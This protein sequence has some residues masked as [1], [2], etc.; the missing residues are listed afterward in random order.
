MLTPET[1]LI[2]RVRERMRLIAGLDAALSGRAGLAMLS[3]EAGIGKTRLAEEVAGEA[4][5]RGIFTAWGRCDEEGGAPPYWPWIQVIRC[6]LKRF[7]DSPA[8]FDLNG[9]G[10]ETILAAMPNLVGGSSQRLRTPRENPHDQNELEAVRF[11]LFDS[12]ATRLLRLS[13]QH[14]LVIIFDDL[15]AADE[16]SLLLLRFVAK[17]AGHARMFVVATYRDFEVRLAPEGEPIFADLARMAESLPLG[18]MTGEEVGEFIQLFCGHLPARA[19]SDRLR[20]TTNGN[21]F[22]VREIVRLMFAEGD[23]AALEGGTSESFKIPDGVRVTIQRRFGFLPTSSLPILNAAAV[24]GRRFHAADLER[25]TGV[26]FDTVISTLEKMIIAGVMVKENVA[27]GAFQFSH[28]LFAESLYQSLGPTERMTLHLKIAE[29]IEQYDAKPDAAEL[30]WHYSRSLP[31]GRA[32]NAVKFSRVAAE[33]AQNALAYQDAAVFYATALTALAAIPGE[34]R[35]S[36]CELLLGLGES[37]YLAGQFE[38]FRAT[39][40]EALEISRAL[41][42]PRLFAKAVLGFNSLPFEAGTGGESV[43]RLHE[44]ALQMLGESE[45]SLRVK[46]LGELA[47]CLGRLGWSGDRQSSELTMQAVELA[48]RFKAPETLAEALFGRYFSLR[49]PDDMAQRLALSEELTKIVD[50][51][52][53]VGWSFRT[54]YYRGA[55]LLEAGDERAWRELEALQRD[56]A[57][58]TAHHGIVEATEAMRALMEQPL[59]RA[60]HAVQRAFDIGRERPTSLARQIF[61]IQLFALRREQGRSHELEQS[62]RRATTRSPE[63]PLSRCAL[64]LAYAENGRRAE[65]IEQFDQVAASGFAQGHRDFQWLVS[66]SWLAEVCACVSDA[67]RARQIYEVLKEYADRVAVVGALL[68]LGSVSRYLGLL[69]M[70]GASLADAQRHFEA[71]LQANKRLGATIWVAHCHYDCALLQINHGDHQQARVLLEEC[72]RAARV[73]ENVRLMEAAETLVKQLSRRTEPQDSSGVQSPGPDRTEAVGD[74][75]QN[76][77]V[78]GIFRREGDFWTIVYRKKTTRLKDAKGLHYIAYLLGRPNEQIRAPDLAARI[79]GAGEEVTGSASAQDLARTEGFAGDLGHAGEMLDAQAKADYK[80]RLQELED[81]LE[82]AREFGNEERVA[83]AEDEKEAVAHELRRA[84][85]L[86]GRDRRA[87]SSAERARSAV[88][89]AIRLALERIADQDRDLG[90]LLST[91][92]KTGTACS[93][94][95]D[96]RFPVSWRL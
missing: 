4:Q 55:D 71:G 40:E 72:L 74:T 76:G 75:A 45:T 87:A 27:L 34:T 20:R 33:R 64:A 51:N 70:T 61:N 82:E 28:P 23:E 12:I 58:R 63:Q 77:D 47:E 66:M 68:C 14:P 90:R 36:R 44:E 6:C 95:P 85:G 59:E 26:D 35:E 49:G 9:P 11:Q 42:N 67:V 5:T 62:L 39:F 73:L 54:L 31:L 52:R 78:V 13:Q 46:L 65:A 43:V 84:M 22:F 41:G 21:P 7:G 93:Y 80:R 19:M 88:T 79:A 3:G 32:E 10:A 50:T 30:A 24:I 16:A 1:P 29:T 53:L 48:R 25:I 57:A 81:E 86:G 38:R 17:Q 89:R 91:T 37:Q 96:D 18:G 83:K 94:V 8:G 2:G 60:E 15:H 56:G 92:I 69:A